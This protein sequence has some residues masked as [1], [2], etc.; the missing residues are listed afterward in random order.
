MNC[1]DVTRNVSTI[2]PNPVRAGFEPRFTVEVVN[3]VA[4]P[5]PTNPD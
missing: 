5:A 2:L 4:K 1:R 3:L